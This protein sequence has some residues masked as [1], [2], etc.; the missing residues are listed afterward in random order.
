M[1]YL[2]LAAYYD[3]TLASH[4]RIS[5]DTVR[6]V[7]RLRTSGRR[8]AI[9]VTGQRMDDLLSVCPCARLFD[10]V[11]AENGAVVYNPATREEHH[12]ANPPPKLLIKGLQ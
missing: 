7:E 2:A 9:L 10:L 3:G 5:E 6:A 8:R 11:V 12:L 4:D 1:H